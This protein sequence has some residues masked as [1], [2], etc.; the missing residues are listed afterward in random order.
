MDPMEI[1]RGFRVLEGQWGWIGQVFVVVL[2]VMVVNFV[3]R[4]LLARLAARLERT[5]NLW[6]DAMIEAARRPLS[7]AIWV[8][9]LAFAARIVRE[10]TGAVIFDAAEPLREIGVIG[11]LAWFLIRL[12]NGL[13]QAWLAR[14]E[15]VDRTTVDAVAKLLRVSVV[16][17][18]ALVMLQTL[19]FSISGVLAFGGIGGIAVGFAARDLLANFF[20]GLMVYLDRP[21]AVGDW[22]YSP[23]RDIEGTVERIGWRLTQIRTFDKRPIYVPNATFTSIA[24]VNPSRMTHRRIH[25]TIGVRY[26][27]V[28][29]VPAI[30]E[31][32]RRMLREH[33]EIAQD[34]TL[35]VHFNQFGPSSL[36]FFVYCFTRTTQWVRY[37]EVKEDV[38]LRIHDIIR[39]HGAEVAFP[40][41]TV[42]VPEP[43]ELAGLGLGAQR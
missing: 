2:A 18:A 11:A 30:L 37:H 36:D 34:Q 28:D 43:V 42:H 10:A 22:I 4:R 14:G 40:T 20:G 41:T 29:K 5:E 21:F 24:V 38:L 26:D 39:R 17:T 31:D 7:L 33:P 6:D 19:G 8:V 16:I 3:Q 23:D 27:D 12:V 25:E 35:M 1:L 9:G 32:I 15:G 13:E